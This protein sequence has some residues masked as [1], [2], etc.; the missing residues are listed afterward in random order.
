MPLKIV[1]AVLLV[2]H[3]AIH[4]AGF[5]KAYGLA[6][7]P[8]LGQPVSHLTGWLWLAAGAGFVASAVLL[9]TGGRLWWTAAGAALVISQALI[10]TDF[11]DARLGTLVN[12]VV[13]IPVALSLVDLRPSSLS[14]LYAAEVQSLVSGM[15]PPA[16]AAPVTDAELGSL[17]PQVQTY[18]RRAGVV[19]RPHVRHLH[20]VFS[21]RMRSRPDAPWMTATVEQDNFYGPPGPAR[22]FFMEATRWGIPF[23]AFHRYVGGAA[24]MQVRLA[25]LA[26]IVNVKGPVMTQS[27]TVTLFNDMCVLAPATLVE[28]PV[29]WESLGERR[30]KA[31]YTNA[32]NTISAVLSF[33]DSGDLVGFVSENRYQLD[34]KTE[35]RFPWSTPLAR[36]RDF[37]PARL[38]REG[39]A[40]W[41]EPSGEWSYG[42]FV[43]EQIT[44]D[45]G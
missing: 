26:E 32:G 4:A 6:A 3:G 23:V 15:A 19:G 35:R 40:R 16:S 8:R 29:H 31:T 44:Y 45:G 14:S 24:S 5:A 9:L 28:A 21:A 17:P 36:Y 34:G 27:E 22:L 33:D 37:G 42:K 7:L 13:L 30:V 2:V 20:A 10:F 43:L 18:L 25:G 1:F 38:A 41:V 11:K 39:E 12:V